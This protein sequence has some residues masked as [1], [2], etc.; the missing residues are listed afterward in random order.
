LGINE[1]RLSQAKVV[2]AGGMESMSNIPYLLKDIRAGLKFGNST[3]IDGMLYDGLID[4]YTNKH[5]G[6]FGELCANKWN[7]TR[8]KQDL[9]SEQS[10]I[11]ALSAQEKNFFKN[12]ICPLHIKT[13]KKT[14]SIYDD[15]EPKKFNKDKISILKPAFMKEGSI[16][17]FNASKLSD[18]AA[19]LIVS[20]KHFCQNI[21]SPFFVFDVCVYNFKER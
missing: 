13:R 8:D 16:T 3:I 15:E 18:G 14:L 19:S 7:I 4:P 20:D 10:Y 1:I 12:E 2:I 9:F 21:K 5:M 17:A 6:E 11:N